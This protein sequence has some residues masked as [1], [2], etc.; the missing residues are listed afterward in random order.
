MPEP[1][2]ELPKPKYVNLLCSF[3]PSGPRLL[4]PC[5]TFH[6]VPPPLG[7]GLAFHC[8]RRSN[9]S[10]LVP[11]LSD[12][13]SF[14]SYLPLGPF[15]PYCTPLFGLLPKRKIHDVPLRGASPLSNR[16][17]P[18]R[19][20]FFQLRFPPLRVPFAA[21][22]VRLVKVYRP[23]HL[24]T[25]PS[26]FGQETPFRYPGPFSSNFPCFEIIDYRATPRRRPGHTPIPYYFSTCPCL[27]APPLIFFFGVSRGLQV[28]V[29]RSL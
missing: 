27:P 15:Q 10:P 8:L 9:L 16:P 11:T 13:A 2:P 23:S 4:L 22:P 24:A 7:G 6:S 25:P 3:N 21:H 28:F 1:Q 5:F 20:V 29:F 19:S 17:I 26:F 14:V 12:S 18:Q